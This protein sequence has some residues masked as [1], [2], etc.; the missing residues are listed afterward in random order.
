VYRLLAVALIACSS[1]PPAPA[2]PPAATPAATPAAAT[3]PHRIDPA[4]CESLTNVQVERCGR[5]R[6][7]TLAYC[8]SLARLGEAGDCI[9]QAQRSF[10]CAI[11]GF[12]ACTTKECCTKADKDCVATDVDFDHCMRGYCSG[13]TGNPDCAA[14]YPAGA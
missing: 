11:T 9:P 10:D 4:M 7:A 3:Q 14:V 2:T 8:N 12:S 6:D 1:S 13:H 5:P